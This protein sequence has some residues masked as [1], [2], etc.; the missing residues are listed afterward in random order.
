MPFIRFLEAF[1][2]PYLI[3]SDNETETNKAVTNQISQSKLKDISINRV[4]FLKEGNDFEKELCYHG[5]IDEVKKAYHHIKLSECTNE[6]HKS[7]KK[8]ELEKIPDADYYKLVTAI[9]TQ[10]APII[11]DELYNS[12]KPL[13][14]KIVELFEKVN[15]ILKPTKNG[16]N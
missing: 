14:P 12:E 4:V 2:I 11:G 9:K 8:E 16:A 7:A 10:F 5:Y 6:N 15:L 13:P 3:F 1:N